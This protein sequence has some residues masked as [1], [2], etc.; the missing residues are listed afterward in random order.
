MN[1]EYSDNSGCWGNSCSI[2]IRTWPYTCYCRC[3]CSTHP[4][5]K[6]FLLSISLIRSIFSIISPIFLLAIFSL[7]DVQYRHSSFVLFI[8]RFF[9][10]LSHNSRRYRYPN[11]LIKS[12]SINKQI[13]TQLCPALRLQPLL[14]RPLG[15]IATE[16][17]PA[18]SLHALI[19]AIAAAAFC[20]GCCVDRSGYPSLAVQVFVVCLVHEGL[21]ALVSLL[22]LRRAIC[23]FYRLLLSSTDRQACAEALACIG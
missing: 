23:K 12:T 4:T 7:F 16:A 15:G 3:L 1:R 21:L 22:E 5:Y 13:L 6:L 18:P 8:D 17:A 14:P 2:L 20:I 10:L 19:P 9:R 11:K